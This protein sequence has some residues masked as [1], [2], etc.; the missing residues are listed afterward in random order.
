MVT[1]IDVHAPVVLDGFIIT[2]G[3]ADFRSGSDTLH[4]SEGGCQ[5]IKTNFEGGGLFIAGYQSRQGP[6][7]PDAAKPTGSLAQLYVAQGRL[8]EAGEM[9]SRVLKILRASFGKD[10]PDTLVALV[11][12]GQAL[13]GSKEGRTR[14]RQAVELYPTHPETLHW[15]AHSIWAEALEDGVRLIE[16]ALPSRARDPDLLYDLACARSRS[17]DLEGAENFLRRSIVAGFRNFDH[18]AT[19]PDLRSLRRT[20][21]FRKLMREHRR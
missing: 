18:I 17:D 10:N 7:H 20:E 14:S 11:D 8:E 15:Y 19:D 6:N 4:T 1:A 16:A 21:A 5:F 12:L 13:S 9:F 3:N 2:G